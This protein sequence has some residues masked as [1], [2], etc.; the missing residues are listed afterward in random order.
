MKKVVVFGNN[1]LADIV[2]FYLGEEGIDSIRVLNREFLPQLYGENL[3]K[4]VLAIE[5]AIEQYGSNQ[6]CAYITIGYNQMNSIRMIVYKWLKENGVEILN[7]IH[8]TSY[9]ASNCNVGEGNIF[10]ENVVVQPYVSIGNCNI[11]FSNTTICHHSKVN[12]FNYFSPGSVVCGRVSIGD[13]NFIG[14]NCTVRN[15]ISIGDSCILG[16]HTLS[17]KD[18]CDE[19]VIIHNH[20]SIKNGTRVN[21]L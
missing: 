3:D 14:A 9:I 21:L 6:L 5:E 20:D 8:N 4:E 18:I 10:L 17:Y 12:N 15:D 1:A 16:A 13:K 19:G 7:F 11:F 2:Q